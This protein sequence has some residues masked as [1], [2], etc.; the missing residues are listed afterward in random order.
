VAFSHD[1]RL[2]ASGSMDKT[3]RIWD[4]ATGTLQQ[5]LK[6]HSR[7]VLSVA[8][9]HDSRLLASGS[10]DK[11][12]RIWDAATGTLQQT[13]AVDDSVLTLSFDVT[14]LILIT[15]IGCFKI[16][17]TQ[18][19]SLSIPSQGVDGK[20]SCKG[21][22]INGSWITWKAQNILWL[23]PDFRAITSNISL[24]G[25]IVAVGCESGRVFTIGISLDILRSYF[26]G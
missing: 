26:S 21:L 3:V 22:G 9:S 24:T 14:N 18:V 19:P 1:S 23:P 4:A 13:I 25:S 5:T 16:N 6:G 10:M 20:S 8:F 7:Q 2:L 11:T 15:N 17:G 12:V